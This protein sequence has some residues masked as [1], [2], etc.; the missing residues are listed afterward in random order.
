MR[1]KDNQ[2]Q[3]KNAF[4]GNN[5]EDNGDINFFNSSAFA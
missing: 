1:A 3:N 2:N 4:D 5:F